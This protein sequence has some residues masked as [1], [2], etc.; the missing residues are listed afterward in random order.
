MRKDRGRKTLVALR[1]VNLI[2][3]ARESGSFV[4]LFCLRRA[5]HKIGKTFLRTM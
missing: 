5:R 2:L 3:Q 1:R 4:I